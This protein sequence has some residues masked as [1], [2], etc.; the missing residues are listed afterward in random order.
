MNTETNTI[1]S[2]TI[3]DPNNMEENIYSETVDKIY[4]QDSINSEES[5]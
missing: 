3:I 1:N 4:V 2:D 5:M